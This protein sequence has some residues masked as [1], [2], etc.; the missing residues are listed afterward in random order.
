MSM[1]FPENDPT[2]PRLGG[3]KRA[4]MVGLLAAFIAA[5]V[6]AFLP[7]YYRSQSKILPSDSKNSGSLGQLAAAAATLG[8]G[9]GMADSGDGN[10][11]EILKS[12]S[13]TEDLLNTEYQ[14]HSR[15]W[16]FGPEK[17]CRQTLYDYLKAENIDR[18]VTQARE[19]VSA[20][21]DTKTKIVTLSAETKS[22]ELSQQIVKKATQDLEEFVLVKGRTKGGEK[23]RFAT[24]RLEESRQERESAEAAFRNFLEGNRNYQTSSDP[25]VRLLGT[26]LEADLKLRQQLV[27]TLALNRE[28]ALL[29]EKND[30][31][32]VNILDDANLPID[33]SSPKRVTIVLLSFLAFAVVTWGRLNRQWLR[34]RLL[35]V[36]AGDPIPDSS[37]K[38]SA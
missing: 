32:I 15:P 26:R 22:P 20:S 7:N 29:E 18:A 16:R 28:Q 33:K 4:L 21:I 8:L 36:D 9:G 23:A 6:V 27:L 17:L 38:E 37:Q 1:T 25:T 12:R 13:L 35:D 5:I 24:A 34:A 3:L 2:I 31:P 10:F 19:I 14:F 11:V 30:V